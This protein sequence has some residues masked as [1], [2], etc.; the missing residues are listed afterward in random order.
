VET[1]L[2]IIRE[3]LGDNFA[4]AYLCGSVATGHFDP[5]TSDVDLL[6][7]TEH[8]VSDDQFAALRALHER[9]P[10]EGNEFG[11]PYE[12]YYIDRNTLR[13][14]EPGLSHVKAGIDEEFGWK[15]QRQNWVIERAAVREHAIAVAGPDLATLIEPV[16]QEDVR[17]AAR[18]E[19]QIRIA[20]WAQDGA[21]SQSWLQKRGAQAY[22][23]ITVCRALFT[24]QRGGLPSKSEALTWAV[25]T[26]P[27]EWQPL[28]QW[29][30]D[31]R[32]DQETGTE[33]LAE[34]IR[35]VQW[36]AAESS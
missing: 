2:P 24:I 36:A 6:I 34:I 19:I 27:S 9:V 23:V 20:D 30:G 25:T 16:S 10:L 26:L 33:M 21:E 28:L 8:P 35:F 14:F 13:R 31:H 22:E 7:A 1:V 15:P 32:A 29:A 11:L 4:G 5:R 12:A 18:S 17:T 3:S